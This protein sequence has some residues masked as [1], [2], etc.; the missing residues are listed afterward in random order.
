MSNKNMRL[1]LG[2]LEPTPMLLNSFLFPNPFYGLVSLLPSSMG[3]IGLPGIF[4]DNGLF[5]RN[6]MSMF[7]RPFAVNMYFDIGLI[8]LLYIAAVQRL[9]PVKRRLFRRKIK[10]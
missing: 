6:S 1:G 3:G 10:G 8:F 9:K 2:H 5:D 7:L 4:F